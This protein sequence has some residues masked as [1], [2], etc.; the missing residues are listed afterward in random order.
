MEKELER[1]EEWLKMKIHINLLGK[2]LKKYQ[3]EKHQAMIVY[4]DSGSKNP[5]PSMKD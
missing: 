1:L 5:L 4:K 2:T 3:I